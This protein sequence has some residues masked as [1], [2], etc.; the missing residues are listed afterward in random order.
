MGLPQSTRSGYSQVRLQEL[1]R[2][3]GEWENGEGSGKI[4]QA[5]QDKTQRKL[6]PYRFSRIGRERELDKLVVD[7]DKRVPAA[8]VDAETSSGIAREPGLVDVKETRRERGIQVGWEMGGHGRCMEGLAT[9][10]V[11]Q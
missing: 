2:V 8:K 1:P 9:E 5:S 3:G 10:P 7:S 11:Q 4:G 6:L